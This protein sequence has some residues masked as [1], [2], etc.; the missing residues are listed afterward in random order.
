M[1]NLLKPTKERFLKAKLERPERL[2]AAARKR[3]FESLDYNLV[4]GIA[5]MPLT[6][7]FHDDFIEEAK[8]K[9]PWL[10]ITRMPSPKDHYIMLSVKD[11]QS[12]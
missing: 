5:E 8:S 6:L 11:S 3:F 9:Y 12:A 7:P 2:K 4:S 1:K 10:S